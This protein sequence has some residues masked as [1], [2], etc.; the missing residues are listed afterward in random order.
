[1]AICK[2][3]FQIK[4]DSR[5]QIKDITPLLKEAIAESH[6]QDGIAIVFSPH[7]TTAIVI[8]EYEDRLI[9]D[10]EQAV[11]ELIP[12][13][14]S[15]KHNQIDNNAP[16]HIIGSF[17]GASA[18]VPIDDGDVSLGTWQSIFF[19]ELDGPRNRQVRVRIIGE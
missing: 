13:N 17:L 10:L 8:N 5:I 1:M 19:V 3:S 16:S 7:T 2:R 6:I 14:K 4:T 18:A 9:E 12:W 15:Y 11:E